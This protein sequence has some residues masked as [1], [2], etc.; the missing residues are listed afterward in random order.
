[1]PNYNNIP[2]LRDAWLMVLEVEWIVKDF[3]LF[4]TIASYYGHIDHAKYYNQW[5][6]CL[7]PLPLLK[8]K[9]F[10]LLTSHNR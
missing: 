7:Y 1:M 2:I 9:K 10:C 8:V 6:V 4:A 5:L 3:H